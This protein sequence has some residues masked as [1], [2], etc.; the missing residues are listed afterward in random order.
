MALPILDKPTYKT[1]LLSRKGE[2][3][4]VPFTV[5]EAK[6]MMMARE[7]GDIN[8]IVDS[9]RQILSNCLVDKTIDVKKLAMVDMEWLFLQIQ[10]RSFGEKLPLFFHCTNQVTVPGENGMLATTKDCGHVIKYEV[11]LLKVDIANKDANRRI[12]LS[13]DIGIEMRFPTF[14]ATQILIKNADNENLDTS[15]IAMCVDFVFDKQ[16]VIEAGSLQQ[17]ELEEWIDKLGAK[18]YEQFERFFTSLPTIVQEIETDCS[19]CGYHHKITLEGLSD[20]FE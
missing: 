7:S 9:L 14:E 10:A 19:K 15:L 1:T 8:S 4:F 3:E 18:S 2:V 11:D 13:P 12:M 17:G 16:E 6:L 5:K 20:F